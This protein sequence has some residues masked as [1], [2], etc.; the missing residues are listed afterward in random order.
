MPRGNKRVKIQF[1]SIFQNIAN[2]ACLSRNQT[3]CQ[4]IYIFFR[5]VLSKIFQL[6]GICITDFMGYVS[7]SVGSRK[8]ANPE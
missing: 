5:L 1:L 8:K 6:Y 3:V 2:V 7:E 4:V